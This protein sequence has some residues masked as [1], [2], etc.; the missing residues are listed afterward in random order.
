MEGET[1]GKRTG[2]EGK[3]GVTSSQE[4]ERGYRC[5]DEKVGWRTVVEVEVRLALR[6]G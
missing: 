3:M 1:W 6:T 2:M 5:A 4:G